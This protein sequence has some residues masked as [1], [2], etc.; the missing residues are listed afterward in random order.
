MDIYLDDKK[1]NDLNM[2]I[3]KKEEKLLE[4]YNILKI[5]EKE[6]KYLTNIITDFTELYKNIKNTK[7][8]QYQ[9]LMEIL[10]YL[11]EI[12]QHTNCVEEETEELNK[13]KMRILEKIK[14]IQGDI[15]KLNL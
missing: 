1:I 11:N 9:A 8:Q 4:D 12:N 13:D 6:N 14:E 2:L 10:L 15:N 7:E 5:K 3:K